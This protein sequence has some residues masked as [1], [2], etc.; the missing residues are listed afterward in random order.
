MTDQADAR[1]RA[2]V[3]A[4][5]RANPKTR[6]VLTGCYAQ[7]DP[8]EA[9]ALA[10]VGLVVGN[11]RKSALY[12]IVEDWL[13][14]VEK[15]AFS[16]S[17]DGEGAPKRQARNGY[18]ARPQLQSPFR[19]GSAR[20]TLHT[21]AYLKIQDGCDRRCSYC[22]IPQARGIGVSRPASEVRAH[23][24]ELDAAGVPEIVLTGVNLGWYRDRLESLR[25]VNLVESLLDSLQSA[26]LRISSIEPCDVDADLARLSLH[27]RFCDFLH[28]PVQSGSDRILRAMRRTYSQRS[29]R[30]RIETALRINPRLFLGTD[31]IVGFPGEGPAEF[32]ESLQLLGDY[33][34]ANIHAF[35]FSPRRGA[36]ASEFAV[37]RP[38]HA[39]LK[40]RMRAIAVLRQQN[41]KR[42]LATELGGIREAVVES[43]SEDGTVARGL[44][45][46]YL[47][48]EWKATPGLARGD[49]A[50]LRLLAPCP[51]EEGI[52][53]AE[54]A[55]EASAQ[56]GR[57]NRA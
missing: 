18:G 52:V 20:P 6:V 27:P 12:E 46:N 9:A 26:R 3:R 30:M 55:S 39:E 15:S 40:E 48:V 7:T 11:Q 38:D 37:L 2:A 14:G 47:R 56:S 33:P 23:L 16:K 5:L 36:P 19:Y 10:G 29:F 28:A 50:S 49:K 32:A 57:S 42:Y 8:A 21:R 51:G 35:R 1:N 44:T 45:D 43:I 13:A 4:A 34:F 53:L 41:L 17:D 25:F 54:T 24:R 22:K 31:L